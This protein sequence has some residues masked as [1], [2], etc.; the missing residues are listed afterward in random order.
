MKFLYTLSEA[1]NRRESYMEKKEYTKPEMDV[2]KLRYDSCLLLDCSDCDMG[3]S[4]VP[5]DDVA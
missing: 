3:L 2:V 1:K 5:K 4:T